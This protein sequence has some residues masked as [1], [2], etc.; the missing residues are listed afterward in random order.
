MNPTTLSNNPD[1]CHAIISGAEIF[2]WSHPS[3]WLTAQIITSRSGSRYGS[4]RS[5]TALTMVKIAIARPVPRASA[6]IAAVVDVQSRRNARIANRRSP[7]KEPTQVQPHDE[8]LSSMSRP[9]LPNP[10][11]AAACASLPPA[12]AWRFS[13]S[14]RSRW[15]R[16]SSASS[17]SSAPSRQ[18]YRSFQTRRA[19]ARITIT[20]CRLHHLPDG[21][22]HAVE[23]RLLP[24]QMLSARRA[25][26]VIAR[27]PVVI[28]AFPFALHQPVHQQPLQRRVKRSFAHLHHFVGEAFQLGRDSVTM[29]GPAHQGAED[30]HVQRARQQVG[31]GGSLL[32]HGVYGIDRR[33]QSQ[34]VT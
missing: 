15:K 2:S 17:R 13:S 27:P 7:A 8:R 30:Q 6:V 34:N 14:N 3:C 19:H 11:T 10:R 20:S 18:P 28:G 4:G 23:L 21:A 1:C 32:K 33:Y 31:S 29:L 5:S 24:F 26:A 16:I 9:T 25:D 12:P 22:H